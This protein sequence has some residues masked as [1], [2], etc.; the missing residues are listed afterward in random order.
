MKPNILKT[1]PTAVWKGDIPKFCNLVIYT[2]ISSTF[3]F[4]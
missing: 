2:V 3:F 4:L 1:T